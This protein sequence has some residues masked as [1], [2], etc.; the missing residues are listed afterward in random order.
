ML[1][2]TLGSS[3]FFLSFPGFN[4]FSKV[5]PFGFLK[6]TAKMTSHY[7]V[8]SL[9]YSSALLAGMRTTNK[10]QNKWTSYLTGSF[11]M[12]QSLFVVRKHITV[13]YFH[14]NQWKKPPKFDCYLFYKGPLTHFLI[15][16]Q[17]KNI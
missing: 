5:I 1:L 13:E 10:Q 7:R 3:D 14:F 9:L 2:G 6:T 8:Y 11:A 15:Q 12:Y 17:A 4:I 16:I